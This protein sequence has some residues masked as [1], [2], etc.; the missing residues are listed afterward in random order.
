MKT[1][2][3]NKFVDSLIKKTLAGEIKW[4][5]LP[6]QLKIG[7]EAITDLLGTCEFHKVYFF[8]SYFCTLSPGHVFLVSELNE[9][10]RDSKYD[11]EGYNLYLQ[12]ADG[13]PLVSVMFD[14]SDLYRLQNAIVAK[15]D[16]PQKTIEFMREFIGENK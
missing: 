11:T 15:L 4:N 12:V 16:I 10:G 6:D 13:D 3:S 2:L 9:S 14:T 7:G 8:E 1:D 5:L